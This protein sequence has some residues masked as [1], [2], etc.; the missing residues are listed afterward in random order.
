MDPRRAN[1]QGL[2]GTWAQAK[3]GKWGGRTVTVTV[4]DRGMWSEVQ[5]QATEADGWWMWAV[6]R[7][8]DLCTGRGGGD[9]VQKRED[10]DNERLRIGGR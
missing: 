10:F 7:W 6:S 1:P 8:V 3:G 4:A 5:R 2:T 9:R